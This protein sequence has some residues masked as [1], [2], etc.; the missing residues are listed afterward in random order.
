MLFKELLQFVNKYLSYYKPPGW[1]DF[2]LCVLTSP[3][4]TL[5]VKTHSFYSAT[6]ELLFPWVLLMNQL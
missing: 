2:S 3:C 4:C 6:A 1:A 5:Q